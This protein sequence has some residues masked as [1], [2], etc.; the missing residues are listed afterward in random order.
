MGCCL[1]V[2]ELDVRAV[3][4]FKVWFMRSVAAFGVAV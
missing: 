2:L 3:V 4:G 1:N